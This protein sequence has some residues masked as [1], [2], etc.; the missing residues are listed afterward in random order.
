MR[1][2][3]KKYFDLHASPQV[4]VPPAAFDAPFSMIADANVMVPSPE[5][6]AG[7]EY[8]LWFGGIGMG[9]YARREGIVTQ[10]ATPMGSIIFGLSHDNRLWLG[11]GANGVIWN[12][13]SA[14]YVGAI[15]N[16]GVRHIHVFV[17][18][19]T[20]ASVL[21]REEQKNWRSALKSAAITALPQ[22]HWQN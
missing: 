13:L 9:P 22:A 20:P 8:G 16:L 2:M 19:N 15:V 10:K 5:R 11:W 7:T 17:R 18:P 12:A 21:C 4:D 1:R 14:V 3:G 6:R